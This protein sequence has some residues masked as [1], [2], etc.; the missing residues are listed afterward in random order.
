MKKLILLLSITLL[1]TLTGCNKEVDPFSSNF[2]SDKNYSKDEQL[3]ILAD[4]HEYILELFEELREEY[5][6]PMEYTTRDIPSSEISD[7][8][9]HSG[10]AFTNGNYYFDRL[11]DAIEGEGTD[12]FDYSPYYTITINEN[13]L[14]FSAT[15]SLGVESFEYVE[16]FANMID[17]KLYYE[18]YTQ[19]YDTSE[20]EVV[21][22]KKAIFHEDEY[23][24]YQ[25]INYVS[26]RVLYQESSKEEAN[27]FMVELESDGNRFMSM[28]HF[29]ENEGYSVTTQ[30]GTLVHYKISNDKY[31]LSENIDGNYFYQVKLTE[32]E[33]WNNIR[34][35]EDN[36]E[37][38]SS[39]KLFNDHAEIVGSYSLI[40][41]SNNLY[42]YAGDNGMVNEDIISL[43]AF[44]LTTDITYTEILAQSALRQT[45]LEEYLED[46]DVSTSYSTLFNKL[47]DEI[48]EDAHTM[49][50]LALQ[51]GIQNTRNN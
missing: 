13:K 17:G 44:N 51:E 18:V 4:Y 47:K 16:V 28:Y 50:F 6:E 25:E 31:Y 38:W 35:M 14:K 37:L 12:P 34:L 29:D 11:H 7:E 32:V 20:E 10:W 43:E 15:L 46:V 30:N 19:L 5:L 21:R 45:E 27:I 22:E 49:E 9:N 23:T 3:E 36:S 2:K 1:L 41:E 8:Y 24:L 48:S 42:F 26:G 33:G 39:Y 40:S